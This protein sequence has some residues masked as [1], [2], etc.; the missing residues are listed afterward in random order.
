MPRPEACWIKASREVPRSSAALPL[1]MARVVELENEHLPDR[2]LH[3]LVGLVQESREGLVDLDPDGAHGD[4]LQGLPP[5][6]GGVLTLSARS[7]PGDWTG[8]VRLA[9]CVKQKAESQP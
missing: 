2:H 5:S 8:Q 6:P 4:R 9:C 1:E 3:R 7:V